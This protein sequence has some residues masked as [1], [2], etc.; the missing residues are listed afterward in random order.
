M[1]SPTIPI[2]LLMI[3]ITTADHK[4]QD[5]AQNCLNLNVPLYL[6]LKKKKWKKNSSEVLFI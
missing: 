4:L 2:I 1:T 6:K 3:R 5:K